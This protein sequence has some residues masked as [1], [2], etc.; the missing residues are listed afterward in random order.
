MPGLGAAA[1]PSAGSLLPK[2]RVL[3]F[4]QCCRR[5]STCGIPPT[6]TR[7][8]C[9]EEG[10]GRA[11]LHRSPGQRTDLRQVHPQCA[12][13]HAENAVTCHAYATETLRKLITST[14]ANIALR[15]GTAVRC[16]HAKRIGKTECFW[17]MLSKQG[18]QNTR[19]TFACGSWSAHP[20]ANMLR[21]T[22]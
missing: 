12:D 16:H 19:A 5:A 4:A 15:G 8:G 9:L 21:P 18:C 17:V 14:G 11:H 20:S 2:I 10:A 3:C 6:H 7:H 13:P 22:S 1:A